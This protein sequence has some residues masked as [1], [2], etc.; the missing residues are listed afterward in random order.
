MGNKNSNEENEY[1]IVQDRNKILSSLYEVTLDK[2]EN[3]GM[4]YYNSIYNKWV[5]NITLGEGKY[6]IGYYDTREEAAIKLKSKL[7][8]IFGEAENRPLELEQFA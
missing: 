7:K 6:T 2:Y 4:I 1:Q 3:S 5:S 8:S